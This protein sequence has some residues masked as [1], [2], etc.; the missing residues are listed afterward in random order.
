MSRDRVQLA[1]FILVLFLL[2]I[3]GGMDFADQVPK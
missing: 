2:A 1:C 3:V